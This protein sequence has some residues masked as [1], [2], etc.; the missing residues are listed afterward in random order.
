[1][2]NDLRRRRGEQDEGVTVGLLATVAR[3][4][5]ADGPDIA[6]VDGVA[7]ALPEEFHTVVDEPLGPRPPHQ[8]ADGEAVDHTCRGV[9]LAGRR[10]TGRALENRLP[11]IVE[12][13]EATCRVDAVGLEEIKK[14]ACLAE[15]PGPVIGG[16]PST[17]PPR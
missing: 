5:L 8:P 7:M 14:T 9:E 3:A 4:V 6:A 16:A 17:S 1:M 13:E 12:K 10:S 15:Q 11:A 2:A